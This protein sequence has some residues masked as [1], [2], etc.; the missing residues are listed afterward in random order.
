MV[1]TCWL[2]AQKGAR[3][4][5]GSYEVSTCALDVSFVGDD[6]VAI[7]GILAAA[8]YVDGLTPRPAE[9]YRDA[10]QH[11]ALPQNVLITRTVALA[12]RS[13]LENEQFDAVFASATLAEDSEIVAAKETCK[14][15]LCVPL[16]NGTNKVASGTAED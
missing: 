4:S 14:R 6:P 1:L 16:G 2:R 7:L 8:G 13:R 5:S 12:A 15:F 11:H 10:G 3:Y 9:T